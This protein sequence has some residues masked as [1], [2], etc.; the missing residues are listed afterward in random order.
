MVRENILVGSSWWN[1]AA[2]FTVA[3]KQRE[4][5]RH[6]GPKIHFKDMPLMTYLLHLGPTS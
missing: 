2:Y 5:E 3:G 4:G 1:K 6:Q